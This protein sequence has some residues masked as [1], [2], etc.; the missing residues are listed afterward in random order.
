MVTVSAMFIALIF[1]SIYLLSIPNGFGGVIH[2]GDSLIYI[3][4]TVL[5][6]PFNVIVAAA[7]PG[8]FNL[9][10]VPHWFPFTIIIK[11]IMALCFTSAG[12]IILNSRNKIAP[13]LAGA[14]NTILYFLGNIILFDLSVAWSALPGL[15]IQAVGSVIF[16]FIIAYTLDKA[17]MKKRLVL[18]KQS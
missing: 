14:I 1:I 11:P 7:G 6:F 10:R 5:P 2:F 17:D 18:A 4:A 8:L 12:S 3:A 16:F 9:V 15:I 13:V